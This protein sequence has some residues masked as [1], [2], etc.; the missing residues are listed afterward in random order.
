MLDVAKV[1][2]AKD[3]LSTDETV[4]VAGALLDR[5]QVKEALGR[6][7]PLATSRSLP[8]DGQLLYLQALA[9][10]GR[11]AEAIARIKAVSSQ[12]GNDAAALAIAADSASLAGQPQLAVELYR[13]VL[14]LTP[15]NAAA[16]R[17]LASLLSD[18]GERHEAAAL[19]DDYHRTNTGDADSHTL[20]AD[21]S[22]SQGNEAKAR[23]EYL[24]AL[25]QLSHPSK[26]GN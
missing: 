13:K 9:R 14:A 22:A 25:R 15:K 4:A 23:K 6:L 1:L 20:A 7:E 10:S 17:A 19:I 18:T 3:A 2:A 24:K 5:G 16:V 21:L 26:E 11:R 8:K 12:Y